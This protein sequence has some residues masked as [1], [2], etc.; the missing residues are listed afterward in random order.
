VQLTVEGRGY[1]DVSIWQVLVS[2][3]AG[4]LVIGADKGV[5]LHAPPSNA[6]GIALL[7]H[8]VCCLS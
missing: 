2:H 8:C 4:F 1:D 3:P 7:Q 5:A 6:G